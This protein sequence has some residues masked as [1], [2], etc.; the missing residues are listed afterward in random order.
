MPKS[1]PVHIHIFSV[2][3]LFLNGNVELGAADGVD[4]GCEMINS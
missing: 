3:V 4:F 1:D 2:S